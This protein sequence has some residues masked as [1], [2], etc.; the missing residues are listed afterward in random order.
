MQAALTQP[1]IDKLPLPRK[2]ADYRDTRLKGLV[3]RITPAGVRTF[4][5]EY[6]RGK[7]VWLGRGDVLGI[8]EARESARGIL[9]QVY[10]GE[11]PIEARRPKAEVPTLRDFIGGDYAT[12]ARANQ[13]AH[14]QNLARLLTAFKALLDKKIDALVP[15]D[16]ERWRAAEV[17]RGLSLQTINRDIAS[18]KACLNRAVDWDLLA[19]NPL[20]KVKKSWVD[21][22]V[23]V[24]YLSEKEEA[25]LRQALDA[26]EERRRTERD[27]ANHWRSERG[28]VLLPSMRTLAFTD[29]LKPLVLLSINTG[30]RRGELFDLTW[31]NVDLD[32]RILTVSGATAKSKRTRHIPLNREAMSVLRNWQT[33][34]PVSEGLV[35]TNDAGLRF[36]R[37]NFSWRKLLKDAEIS[38]F[39]WHDM[40]HHFASR[41]VMGGVDL[42]T[43]RE[44]LGHSDYAMTLRYAHLAPEH[45]LK[46]VEVL[47]RIPSL[48]VA[49]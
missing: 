1:M 31:A 22:C 39:R 4:Y 13:R 12:W 2:V 26:R 37:V 10:R 25:R 19:I 18:I 40:R 23:K 9:A 47:D 34:S 17:E 3:L 41:L 35:F 45:K 11:D 33:Q 16:L 42:N 44:L 30:C 29:H 46:A 14:K 5:C 28:Y 24:R 36:D 38:N 21:D 6:A 32:R 49:A 20:A 8:A 43:V 27:T 7:R 48:A 15:L